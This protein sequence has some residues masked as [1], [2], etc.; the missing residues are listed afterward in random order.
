MN[1]SGK[2]LTIVLIFQINAHILFASHAQRIPLKKKFYAG[3]DA[4]MG[5]PDLTRNDLP[6]KRNSAFP[7]GF[8]FGIVPF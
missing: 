3:I 7:L 6:T 8:N 5:L 4:G 2:V 1:Y